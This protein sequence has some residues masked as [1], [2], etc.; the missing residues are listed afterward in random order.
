MNA[1]LA[2][3]GHGLS[4]KPQL[5]ALNKVDLPD[6][7]AFLELYHDQ[8]DA[9]DIPWLAISGVSGEGTQQLAL[10]TLELLRETRRV[11]AAAQQLPVL[12]VGRRPRFTAERDAEG[13]A[14]L[15]GHTPEWLAATLDVDDLEARA[16]LLTR[17]RRLGV[18]R[19][20]ARVGVESGEWIR[21][22]EVE[23]E[24]ES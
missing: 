20:L 1:E 24:W 5:L 8:I 2:A 21:V 12:P 7:R 4:D 9:L 15:R 14:V 13:T 11:Q 17:L 19:A 22:G 10:R 23:L 18:G 6:G 3:F 16:E